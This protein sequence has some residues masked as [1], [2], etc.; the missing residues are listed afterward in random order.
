MVEKLLAHEFTPERFNEI[1]RRAMRKVAP[2]LKFNPD[3]YFPF[4]WN[5]MTNDMA[6][7]WRGE[8]SLLT[9]LF[10]PQIFTGEPV[11]VVSL[12]AGRGSVDAMGLLKAFE[13]EARKRKCVSIH[14]SSFGTDQERAVSMG[15]LYQRKGYRFEELSYTKDI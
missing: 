1:I 12:W 13:A 6:V 8:A 10:Y 15:N 14:A 3:H 2:G 11:G 4:M 9:G 5:M 7:A